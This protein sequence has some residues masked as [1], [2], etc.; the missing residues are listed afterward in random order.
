ME[1]IREIDQSRYG[2]V[3]KA[4]A[5][6]TCLMLVF[7]VAFRVLAAKLA[8]P[9]TTSPIAQESLDRLPFQIGDWMG[10]DV[11]L[12]AAVIRETDTDAHVNRR[13][14]RR[15]GLETIS[16]YV[17]AGVRARDLMPHRPEVCYVGSGWTLDE[18]RTMELTLANG[19]PLPCQVFVF[20]RGTLT[21]QKV[22]VL[23]YYIVDGQ[24]RADVSAL[25]SKVWRGSGAIGYV[26]QVEVV[27][28]VTGTSDIDAARQRVSGFAIESAQPTLALFQD[29]PTISETER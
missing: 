1:H 13:Y 7:G 17:A 26:G 21:T 16:F 3:V 6:A 28:V 24:Y 10:R 23:Y 25:R 15:T 2:P 29:R 5:A 12:D 27:T 14:D 11:P 19:S 18:R 20:S 22:V 9:V 8:A 4:A